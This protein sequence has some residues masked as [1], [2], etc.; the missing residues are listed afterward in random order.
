[1]P[2]SARVLALEVARDEALRQVFWRVKEAA[3]EVTSR[4]LASIGQHG[5]ICNWLRLV[6]EAVIIKAIE[7]DRRT[8]ERE[9]K[10]LRL[11]G[12]C[13]APYAPE[14]VDE[15]KL[16]VRQS[17]GLCLSQIQTSSDGR[18]VCSALRSTRDNLFRLL[19]SEAASRVD[20]EYSQLQAEF[21]VDRKVILA[22]RRTALE[23]EQAPAAGPTAV[24]M[25]LSPAGPP[26]WRPAKNGGIMATNLRQPIGEARNSVANDALKASHEKLRAELRRASREFR[27]GRKGYSNRRKVLAAVCS[28]VHALRE[29]DGGAEELLR[30]A[31]LVEKACAQWPK[32]AQ[33]A[34]DAIAGVQFVG[35]VLTRAIKRLTQA[36]DVPFWRE[37]VDQQFGDIELV[38]GCEQLTPAARNAFKQWR[39]ACIEAQQATDNLEADGCWF[40][41]QLAENR[42]PNPSERA[43]YAKA[44]I[45]GIVGA[46][47][48]NVRNAAKRLLVWASVQRAGAQRSEPRAAAP[49]LYAGQVDLKDERFA[50]FGPSAS[51]ETD[52]KQPEQQ[53]SVHQESEPHFVPLPAH[54]AILGALD[55]RALR[56]DALAAEAKLE[57]RSLFDRKRKNKTTICGYLSELKDRKLVLKHTRLGYY[58]PDRPPPE[59]KQGGDFATH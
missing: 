13:E 41:L 30:R 29:I 31:T 4:G 11:D 47:L 19:E 55:G 34:L 18:I 26:G 9:L 10:N 44:V 56:T 37:V 38:L 20:A 27:R 15:L 16:I 5:D 32:Y 51:E 12:K 45:E 36:R 42:S 58:R 43:E 52:P 2:K 39:A 49:L 7:I 48:K 46:Y 14:F 57:R 25:H 59:L 53:T 22:E 23:N 21:E 54:K 17:L 28:F 6:S 33:A 40:L 3:A 50:R 35:L 8:A 24:A 1:M